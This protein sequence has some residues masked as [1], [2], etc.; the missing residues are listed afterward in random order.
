VPRRDYYA[1]LGVKKSASPDE[2]KRAFRALAKEYHPDKNPDDLDA[3]RR[4]REIMEAYEC[5]SDPQERARYDRIGPLYRPDGKPPSPDDINNLFSDAVQTLFRRDRAE[6]RGEDLRHPM[7]LSLEEVATG[8]ERTIELERLALCNR[9]GGEGAD[10][11]GGRKDCEACG[12]TGKSST[13]RLFRS[14]CPRCDGRGFVITRHC[15]RC[16]GKGRAAHREAIKVKV[17]P[18]VATGQKLKVRG[19]GNAGENGGPSGDLFVMIGVHEHK[20]FQ[21]RGSDLICDVPLFLQEAALGAELAVPTLDGTTTIRIP[22]GTPSG[23]VFRLSGRGLP[24]LDAGARGDLHL[25][26]VIEVPASLDPGA[27]AA[28]EALNTRL[29]R[30]AYPL[31]KAYDEQLR[32]RP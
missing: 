1:A 3:G 28:L 22:P 17:P 2:I 26:T 11:D 10:P 20:L 8:S 29:G 24:K 5:L 13:R 9:C 19:K 25:R 32:K 14:D 21:R 7:E 4:F 31:R 12:A 16:E 27:R 18:G 23:K 6:R 30:D 15:P